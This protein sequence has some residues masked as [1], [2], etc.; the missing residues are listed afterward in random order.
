M[1]YIS[2]QRSGL[3]GMSVADALYARVTFH[4]CNFSL[5][6]EHKMTDNN[7]LNVTQI[8]LTKVNI[9]IFQGD[10]INIQHGGIAF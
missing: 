5:V 9:A 4:K 8:A 3:Y 1:F 2:I 6:L 7:L 10:E